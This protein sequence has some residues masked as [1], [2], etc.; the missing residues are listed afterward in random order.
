MG[1]RS[2]LRGNRRRSPRLPAPESKLEAA[3]AL[4]IRAAKI[5]G[6]QREVVFHPTRKW[7]LDF[8]HPLAKLAVEVEGGI[9]VKGGHSTGVGITRDTEKGNEALLMGIRVLRVTGDQI[10]TGQALEWIQRALAPDSP[11]VCPTVAHMISP[12]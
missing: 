10:R 6:F 9:W 5:E 2:P 12:K 8:Y 1:V 11:T 4:Q 7:R 3:L